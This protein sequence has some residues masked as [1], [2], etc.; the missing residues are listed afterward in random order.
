MSDSKKIVEKSKFAIVNE[1]MVLLNI[2]DFGKMESFVRKTVKDLEREV[3]TEERR[4][5][6]FNHNKSSEMSV[7]E[8]M[9]E[10][11]EAAV[12]DAY[13]ALDPKNLTDNAA[14]R[15]YKEPYL[16]A[17]DKAEGIVLG[18]EKQINDK[19][20]HYTKLIADAQAQIDVRKK[21]ITRLLRGVVA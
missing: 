14:Q 16:A 2:G 3:E 11:A 4:I 6:N 10:D 13:R 5:T 18:Y 12:E 1:A 15:A 21:R 20:E 17:I 8:E 7:L 19:K 9:V